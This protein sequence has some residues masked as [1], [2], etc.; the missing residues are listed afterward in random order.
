MFRTGS[1]LTGG[2]LAALAMA[3]NAAAADLTDAV[4]A[5]P[6]E[7][8]AIIHVNLEKARQTPAV[9]KIRELF[10]V[11]RLRMVDKIQA[12]TG[13]DIEKIKEVWIAGESKRKGLVILK[14]E[15]DADAMRQAAALIGEEKVEVVSRDGVAFAAVVNT[16]RHGGGPKLGVLVDEST[17]VA[18]DQAAV[19]E[20]LSAGKGEGE[21]LASE[22]AGTAG[23]FFND[24]SIVQGMLLSMPQD[25]VRKNPML[26]SVK[27][28]T[29]VV[30]MD[31]EFKS[32][33]EL[34]VGTEEQAVALEQIINGFVGFGKLAAP[35]DPAKRA[36]H[37]NFYKNLSITREG[38]K[39]TV[40]MLVAEADLS[41]MID[42]LS[43]L[44]PVKGA[45]R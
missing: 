5:M 44:C 38:T 17:L 9:V 16:P 35:A 15:F 23:S 12:K 2:A 43:K 21:G 34:L 11:E 22:A 28:G 14:G 19:E 42:S 18:G 30:D 1:G 31:K 27:G 8:K 6:K 36:M 3:W 40:G 7:T 24:A 45:E 26:A 20:Y 13:I 41:Q 37:E 32:S 39:V 4:A 33:L 10:A 25:A 29:L